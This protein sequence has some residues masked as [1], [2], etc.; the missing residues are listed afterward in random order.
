M[1]HEK[2]FYW[3]DENKVATYILTEGDN[4]FTGTASCH[5]DDYDMCSSKTG[6][7]IANI[8]AVIKYYIHLRDNELKPALKILNRVYSEMKTSKKFNYSSY[9][10]KSLRKHI[11]RTKTELA[12]TQDLVDSTKA[13]L[14]KL[15]KEKD[16][17]YKHVRMNREKD[18]VGQKPSI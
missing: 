8:R 16:D 6:L 11:Y 7:Q 2:E 9:E 10:A 15:I 4:V 13:N 1:V 17:F 18:K 12:L 3:D 5:P 14:A